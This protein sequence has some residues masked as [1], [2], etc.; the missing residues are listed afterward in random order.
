V[1]VGPWDR[2]GLKDPFWNAPFGAL[3]SYAD[4]LSAPDQREAALTFLRQGA[5]LGSQAS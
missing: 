1:Y 3:L 2:E 5:A 4:L